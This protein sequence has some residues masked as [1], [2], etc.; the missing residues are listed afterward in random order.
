MNTKLQNK[1]VKKYSIFFDWIKDI[2]EG[3]PIMPIQFGIECGD[4]W[5][6][7]LD[8]LMSE[9]LN[10]HKNINENRKYKFKHKFPEWLQYNTRLISYKWKRIHKAIRWLI[11]LFPRGLPPLA[12][13]N[14]TQIKEKFGG[15]R[16]Y[17]NG[18]DDYVYGATSLA[19]SLSYRIC[20]YCGTTIDVGLTQGWYSTI[21]KTCRE[22]EDNR[23]SLK[24]KQ[25]ETKSNI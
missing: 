6:M 18:G 11:N 19:E 20:E 3:S 17:Y 15:L 4:G 2:P 21:C 12:P 10:H 5:Y 1:L 9:L 23:K 22:K 25:N 14:I 16:F 7:L 8:E 13:I 24:W